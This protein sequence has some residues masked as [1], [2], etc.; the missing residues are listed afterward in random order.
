MAVLEALPGVEVTVRIAGADAVEYNNPYSEEDQSLAESGTCCPTTTKYIECIDDAEF[1]IKIAASH[2]YAWGYKN[3]SLAYRLSVD[4]N[5]ISRRAFSCPDEVIID[6]KRAVCPKSRQWSK[7]T[8]KFSAVNTVDDP[9]SERLAQDSEVAKH[10]GLIK[11][12][13]RRIIRTADR[14]AREVIAN[15]AQKFELAEKSI[16]G[17]AISHGTVFSPGEAISTPQHYMSEDL[18]EDTGP[19]AVFFFL[20]RSRDALQKQLIIPRDPLPSS[21]QSFLQLSPAEIERLAKERF[22][23]MQRDKDLKKE[24]KPVLKRE[25]VAIEDLTG[26]DDNPRPAK[27]PAQFIDLTL[28]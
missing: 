6:G 1:A 19:L 18:P 11:V 21:R 24:S 20:Y 10:L 7:Y 12:D 5:T 26:E 17:K 8:L 22:E 3:H 14:N 9:T 28:D 2:D 27:R 16:K 15:H 4:G 23:Q 13:F 25:A